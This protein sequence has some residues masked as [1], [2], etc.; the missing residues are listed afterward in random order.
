MS[1]IRHRKSPVFEETY[2][3]YLGEIA[4]LDL[5]ERAPILGGR[6]D[7]D[8]LIISLYNQAY[9]ISGKAI[10]TIEGAAASD[11]ARIILAQYVLQC[12]ESVPAVDDSWQPYRSFKDAAPLVSYVQTN[13]IN[14]LEVQ[15]AGKTGLLVERAQAMGARLQ[16]NPSFDVSCI[17]EALARIKILL[18]FNDADEM[19]PAAC[20]LLFNSSAPYFLDMECVAVLATMLAAML[21]ADGGRHAPPGD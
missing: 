16:T 7:G 15:C 4:A 11:A 2:Q 14:R 19:F 6:L 5:A 8:G 13:A 21:L 1:D 9:R 10:Q 17:F 20:T 12:P 3:R 18:N